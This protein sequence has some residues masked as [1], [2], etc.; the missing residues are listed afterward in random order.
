M[1]PETNSRGGSNPAIDKLTWW[2]SGASFSRA[3]R[4]AIPMARHT[5]AWTESNQLQRWG[6]FFCWRLDIGLETVFCLKCKTHQLFNIIWV[7]VSLT[8]CNVWYH[9]PESL[10]ERWDCFQLSR[11]VVVVIH[12]EY[13]QTTWATKNFSLPSK[14]NYLLSESRG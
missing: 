12:W 7:Y 9:Q 13:S 4:R 8:Q 2:I 3:M 5:T 10:N 1:P 11:L 6:R 14:V